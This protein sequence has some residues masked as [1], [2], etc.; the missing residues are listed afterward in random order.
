MQIKNVYSK[1]LIHACLN[2]TRLRLLRVTKINVESVILTSD[3][4]SRM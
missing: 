3:M 2:D 1:I 4:L